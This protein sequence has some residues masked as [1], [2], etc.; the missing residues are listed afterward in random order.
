VTITAKPSKSILIPIPET[1]FD[2]T[3]VSVPWK[4]LT[5]AGFQVIFA[6]PEGRQ[7]SADPKIISGD[8]LGIFKSMLIADKNGRLAYTRLQDDEKFKNPLP[9]QELKP[10]DFDALILPGGHAPGMKPYLESSILQAFVGDFFDQGKIVGAIC[11]GVLLAARSLSKSTG[12]SV[13]WGKKTTALSAFMELS[14]WRLTRHAAGDYYRTYPKTVQQEVTETLKDP[15]DFIRGP[16]MISLRSIFRDSLDNTKI[17]FTV[18]DGNY[19]SARWP[20]DAHRFA[21]DLSEMLGE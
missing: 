2:P 15:A 20:G 10:E 17:G 4:I 12:K 19:I 1:D 5:S 14:A 8:G 16:M 21:S 7:G 3:E 9:Y 18:K 11:H 6:T 13:L